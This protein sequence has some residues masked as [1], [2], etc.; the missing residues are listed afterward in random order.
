MAT[1]V[2]A[3]GDGSPYNLTVVERN[4]ISL[5]TGGAGGIGTAGGGTGGSVS[6]FAACHVRLASDANMIDTLTG[7]R[8]GNAFIIGNA[9]GRG[10]DSTAF[11]AALVPGGTSFWDTIQTVTKGAPGTGTGSPKSYAVGVLAIGNVTSQTRLTLTNATLAGI[12][13]L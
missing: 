1:G 5:L 3:V 4:T 8:G 9:A 7:G 2:L 12:G 6:G 10:G 11:I 13:D